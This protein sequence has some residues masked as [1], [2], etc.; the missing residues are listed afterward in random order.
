[1]MPFIADHPNIAGASRQS[2]TTGKQTPPATIVPPRKHYLWDIADITPAI[3]LGERTK[4][5][6]FWICRN[7][8]S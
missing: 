2:A 7:C 6:I 4:M 3:T 1:G 8:Q 5:R